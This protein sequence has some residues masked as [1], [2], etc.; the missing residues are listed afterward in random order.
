MSTF[1]ASK[2]PE[3][4]KA[5]E[6]FKEELSSIRTGRAN[7]ALVENM[8]VE[9]YDGMMELKGLASISVPDAKTIT[10]EPWDKS[11][12]QSIEQ[13]IQKSDIGINPV[14]DGALIRLVMPQMTEEN[15][16]QFVKIVREKLEEARI[17]VRKVREHIKDEVI[18]QEKAKEITEDARYKLIEELDKVVKEVNV[19]LDEIA[20]KKEE[21]ITTV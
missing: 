15:R 20:K 6:H 16:A 2:K 9:A 14:N 3:F 13:A 7:S 1:I 5:V 12:L 18:E 19:E 17:T 10:I 4:D 8:K 21:E 11:V